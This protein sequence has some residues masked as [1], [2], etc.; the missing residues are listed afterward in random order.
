MIATGGTIIS[1]A[2]TLKKSGAKAVMLAATHGILSGNALEKFQNS[3]IEKLILVDTLPQ[4][5][6]IKALGSRVEILPVAPMIAESL[7]RVLVGESVA[8]LFH[9]MNNK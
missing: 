4:E 8:E 7:R 6:T 2:E 9:D 1:A 5:R 3:S